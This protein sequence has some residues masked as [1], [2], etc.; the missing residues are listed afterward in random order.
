MARVLSNSAARVQPLDAGWQLARTP[1][2]ALASPAAL[3]GAS[4][5]WVDAR[6]PGTA[7]QALA[8]AGR[9]D[10]DA[11][12][13][14][15]GDDVWYRCAFRWDGGPGARLHL[16]G[17]ATLCDV[18]LNGEH[19][20]RSENMF[21]RHA[22]PVR[23]GADN[24]LVLRFGA[25]TAFL[26]AKKGRA[27]WRPMM[28]QPPSVRFART[29]LLGR[30]PS[31]CPAVQAVGPW[32][33]IR[34]EEGPLEV[35]AL[36]ASARLDGDA[37]EVA[38]ALSLRGPAADVERVRLRV[39]DVGVELP[40]T[41]A[42]EFSGVARVERVER[43]WP[44]TH[45]APRRYPVVVDVGAA[46]LE[47]GH[48]GF[49]SVTLDRA[50]DGF[51]VFVNGERVFCRG[52]CWTS[53]D[54]LSLAGT[55]EAYAPWL[56]LAKDAGMNMLRVP[57]VAVY[58]SPDF[59]A[60]CDELGVLVWQDFMF[61]N[62]DY[63]VAE[64]GFRESV[65]REAAGFLDGVQLSPSLAVLCGGSEVEQQ[66]AM[67]GL[68]PEASSSPLHTEWLP[69]LSQEGR[70]DVPYVT[71]SPTGGP[72]PFVS[73]AGCAHYYGVGAYRR[74]L[75]DARRADVR[76]A[77]ECLGFANLPERGAFPGVDGWEARVPK[78]LGAS[79]D[80]ADV[81]DHYLE[82]LYGEDA[83]A[84]RAVE[85][86]RYAALSR[87]VSG[88]VMGEVFAEWR[89]ARSRCG[90]GLVWFFQDLWASPGWGVVDAAGAPKPA[91][92]ALKRAFA[93]QAVFL[94]DEGVN[95]V[96]VRVVNER[97]QALEAT[98]TLELLLNGKVPVGKGERAV[99]VPPRGALELS[100]FALLGGFLDVSYA[101]RFGAPQHHV[102]VATLR[103]AD[104]RALGEAFHFPVGRKA[105]RFPD[106]QVTARCARDGD[107][108]SLELGADGFVQ[109]VRVEA[110]GYRAGDGGF[111]LLAGRPKVV[112]LVPAPGAPP[113]PSGE[114]RALSLAQAIH[115]SGASTP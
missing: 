26:A 62:F 92:H 95:G 86:E 112:R 25:L 102:T 29:T 41:G 30:A 23:L 19:L 10:P 74:P 35:A 31:W 43:W 77:S 32:R 96:A 12:E 38:L 17:L 69:R 22:L 99:S 72:L 91:W 109:S 87:E 7:A 46:T 108:W 104:G 40:R 28:L 64:P 90:G 94:T 1:A 66:A 105:A 68:S 78:D 89:R 88:E 4:L 81:R 37:G 47:L 50:D 24:Q 110:P 52:A 58:E 107:G 53:A 103:A 14:L 113:V 84:L 85:P 18:W 42:A 45:G 82:L 55:R 65:E 51:T 63:P 13:P 44:H 5:D 101:Y 27:R 80:F 57:G 2:G 111:H 36:S 114:V 75:D 98:V 54:L 20:L 49:R 59:F 97:A 16:D 67:L 39:G 71:N 34:L 56:A 21:H 33:G 8:A 61:A 3:D 83:K 11:P 76:F 60:L 48:T 106:V 93:S 73:N 70:P 100:A 9:F 15:D 115:F 79:Y 6:V